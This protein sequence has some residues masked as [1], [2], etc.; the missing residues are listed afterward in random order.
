[1]TE[2]Q[3]A[4]ARKC[5]IL[6]SKEP[7]DVPDYS[8][9]KITLT[10]NEIESP[11]AVTFSVH[12]HMVG[13]QSQYFTGIFKSKE[14]KIQMD[15]DNKNA[16]SSSTGSLKT[17]VGVG[18]MSRTKDQHSKIM[19][20]STIS[21]Q[22][23]TL[24]VKAF[25]AFLDY[26]Y[27]EDIDFRTNKTSPVPLLFLCD[28]LQMETHFENKVIQYAT[29]VFAE[30]ASQEKLSLLYD[31]IILF[32]AAGLSVTAAQTMASKLCYET[33]QLL[34][35]ET[36]LSSIADLPLWLN[37]VF[38]I[39]QYV[40][41]RGEGGQQPQ[42]KSASREWSL[43]IAHFLEDDHNRATVDATSFQK[44]TSAVML[45][46]VHEHATLR[47]LK[48]EQTHA[49]SKVY[50]NNDN[51]KKDDDDDDNDDGEGDNG[52]T[53]LPQLTNLQNRCVESLDEAK[54]ELD[55]NKELRE[56]ATGVMYMSPRV[57]RTYLDRTLDAYGE[58]KR[59]LEAQLLDVKNKLQGKTGTTS[60]GRTTAATNRNESVSNPLEIFDEP[61]PADTPTFH[62]GSSSNMSAF[63]SVPTTAFPQ[64]AAAPPP[65]PLPMQG[66]AQMQAQ[67][68]Q[69]Q[70]SQLPMPPAVNQVPRRVQQQKKEQQ[71]QSRGGFPGMFL[72]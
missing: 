56:L 60:T 25:E 17:E 4:G 70:G 59:S 8:D 3:G 48:E 16:L 13:P 29:S 40:E 18:A 6:W 63:P 12:R 39:Q 65:P 19:F 68:M 57:M 10:K 64:A 2:G 7:D 32:R 24:I 43:H 42:S 38:L 36:P 27:L 15:C 47:L 5:R 61:G 52:G 20:P 22:A 41:Q 21:D 28:Y 33:K 44:L 55:S 67:A 58:E 37:V 34:S 11:S 30:M 31:Q 71:Q 62:R 45:P 66:Q 26:C 51:E 50:T 72:K 53:L 9:W 35:K 54:L 69:A 1:M 14:T 23:F 46:Y 49:S